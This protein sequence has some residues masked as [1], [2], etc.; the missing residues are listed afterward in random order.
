MKTE[1]RIVFNLKREWYDKIASGEKTVEYREIKVY[2]AKR[3]WVF[4]GPP[5][6]VLNY[7]EAL[8]SPKDGTDWL[9]VF[10]LGYSRKYPDIVRRITKIDIWP[11]PYKGWNDNYF[12]VHFEREDA[13]GCDR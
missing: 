6:A 9:A 5:N 2:W 10:R 3:L 4:P 8:I 12:R 1:K 11:C 13:N 7:E